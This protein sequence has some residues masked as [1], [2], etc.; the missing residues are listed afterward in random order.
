[1]ELDGDGVASC[2]E[3]ISWCLSEFAL[4]GCFDRTI[5]SWS[6]G[7]L[8]L[9]NPVIWERCLNDRP[10]GVARYLDLCRLQYVTSMVWRNDMS[11]NVNKSPVSIYKPVFSGDRGAVSCRSRIYGGALGYPMLFRVVVVLARLN[12][13]GGTLILFRWWPGF[14]DSM[15]KL[16]YRDHVT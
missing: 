2:S 4:S 16:I 14:G 10:V 5:C 6:D 1:M 3:G 11:Y 9:S 12:E 15:T 13:G 7:H 8:Q